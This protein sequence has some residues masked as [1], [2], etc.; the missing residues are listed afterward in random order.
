MIREFVGQL[1]AM[2]AMVFGGFAAYSNIWFL[3]VFAA[4]LAMTCWYWRELR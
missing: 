3:I 2:S 1:V 4:G